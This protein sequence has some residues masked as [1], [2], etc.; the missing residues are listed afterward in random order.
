MPPVE[1]GRCEGWGGK[2]RRIFHDGVLTVKGPEDGV[3]GPL[4]R[5][6]HR[7]SLLHTQAVFVPSFGVLP[8]LP[9]NVR[10]RPCLPSSGTCPYPPARHGSS[11]QSRT[12]SLRPAST[13]ANTIHDT[14]TTRACSW[15]D[16]THG[17]GQH[18]CQSCR[19]RAVLQKLT[20]MLKG[21]SRSSA[22]QVFSL[23]HQ[24]QP[25]AVH[26]SQPA[27]PT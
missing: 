24:A 10:A 6:D 18:A 3:D 15:A 1:E 25:R 12:S 16:S 22:V 21:P 9:R 14:T 2:S 19:G 11:D 8:E 26:S 17:E 23:M 27:G 4:L 20:F 7:S 5:C 13:V